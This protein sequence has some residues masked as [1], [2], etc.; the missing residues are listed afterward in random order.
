LFVVSRSCFHQ[1]SPINTSHSSPI[2]C[3]VMTIYDL[4]ADLCSL[5]KIWFASKYLETRIGWKVL[6]RYSHCSV[7]HQASQHR[8]ML[9][10]LSGCRGSGF[11]QVRIYHIYLDPRTAS[12]MGQTVSTAFYSQQPSCHSFILSGAGFA[13]LPPPH[14]TPQNQQTST[15]HHTPSNSGGRDGASLCQRQCASDN[16]KYHSTSD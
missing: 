8:N 4:F 13:L 2:K 1:T 7:N 15:H 9:A 6:M 14:N 16:D 11:A 5:C 12:L 10:S 3:N